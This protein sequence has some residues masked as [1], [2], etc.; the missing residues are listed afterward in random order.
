M[1]GELNVV[2]NE[3]KDGFDLKGLKVWVASWGLVKEEIHNVINNGRYCVTGAML[4][5][6]WMTS[7]VCVC[8]W[9]DLKILSLWMTLEGIAFLMLTASIVYLSL[10]SQ[11]EEKKTLPLLLLF[12]W[13]GSKSSHTGRRGRCPGGCEVM[14]GFPRFGP[15]PL[16]WTHS[17]DEPG[18][19]TGGSGT[20]LSRSEGPTRPRTACGLP[21]QSISRA[22]IG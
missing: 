10:L 6:L 13:P 22:Q 18:Q 14:A 4:L 5:T 12:Y 11:R 8:A 7:V 1:L 20:P 19:M 2:R 3:M 16:Q 9:S 21:Q 15:G 17:A